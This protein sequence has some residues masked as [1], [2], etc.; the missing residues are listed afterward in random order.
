MNLQNAKGPELAAT[1]PSLNQSNQQ[2]NSTTKPPKKW[3]RVLAAFLTNRTFNRFEAERLLHDHALHSTVSALQARGIIID[4]KFECIPG[5]RGLA[6]WVC[7]YRLNPASVEMAK[8][9]LGT[10]EGER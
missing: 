7:R 10:Q 8:A 6:T 5:Y 2:G 4:R 1:S 3:Q 9:L